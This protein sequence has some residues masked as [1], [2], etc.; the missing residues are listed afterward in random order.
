MISFCGIDCYKCEAYLATKCN[1]S[2]E[3]RKLIAD[4]WSEKYN[5]PGLI[6]SDIHCKGCLSNDDLF[7]KCKTRKKGLEKILMRK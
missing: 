1:Y 5:H 7:K 4:E 2:Y 6:A 3:K